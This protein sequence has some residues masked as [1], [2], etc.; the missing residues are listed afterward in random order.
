[1]SDKRKKFKKDRAPDPLGVNM[2]WRLFLAVPFPEEIREDLRGMIAELSREEWPVRW[3]DPDAAHLTLHFL[4]EVEPERA[5][6]LRMTLDR[7]V[8]SHEPFEVTTEGYGAFPTKSAPRVIWL[9]LAGDTRRLE[10]VH[11]SLAETLQTQGIKIEQRAFRPHV[12]LGRV[13]EEPPEG[14]SEEVRGRLE[15]MSPPVLTIPVNEIVLFRS[16]L[17]KAGA[18]HT[19]LSR[20]R[21]KG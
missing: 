8:G 4:G 1:M 11:K 15:T 19:P 6:L 21:L 13:R 17:G 3:I 12:T 9:G 5:E 14:F 18:T 10:K 2:A 16:I 7:A 20:Y